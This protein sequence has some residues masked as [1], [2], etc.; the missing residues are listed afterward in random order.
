MKHNLLTAANGLQTPIERSQRKST[1]SSIHSTLLTSLLALF[2]LMAGN[3]AMW[4]RPTIYGEGLPG[5]NASG[6]S[7]WDSNTKEMSA[8][9]E[10]NTYYAEFLNVAATDNN[11]YRFKIAVNDAGNWWDGAMDSNNTSESMGNVDIVAGNETQISFKMPFAGDVYVFYKSTNSNESKVWIVAVPTLSAIGNTTAQSKT[12]KYDLLIKGGG[13]NTTINFIKNNVDALTYKYV[14]SYVAPACTSSELSSSKPP[15]VRYE[16]YTGSGSDKYSGKNS[17]HSAELTTSVRRVI[18]LWDGNKNDAPVK[19]LIPSYPNRSS[20]SGWK[21]WANDGTDISGDLSNGS[22]TV[23]IQGGKTVKYFI[24]N[25]TSVTGPN[26]DNFT[27]NTRH[28]VNSF[29]GCYVDKTASSNVTFGSDYQIYNSNEGGVFKIGNIAK[30]IVAENDMRGSVTIDGS[31][32]KDVTFTFDGGVITINAVDHGADPEPPTPSGVT[33]DG[34]EYIYYAKQNSTSIGDWN[35][36]NDNCAMFMEFSDGSTEQRSPRVAFFWD[37]EGTGGNVLAAQVPEG[38]WTKCRLLRTRN[39]E[40]GTVWNTSDWYNLDESKNYL[41][42]GATWSTHDPRTFH[43]YISGSTTLANTGS[44]FN[45]WNGNGTAHSGSMTKL[46]NAGT[47]KFKLNPTGTV[48]WRSEFNM[49]D[50]DQT[51]SNV[52]L[53]DGNNKEIWFDLA[54]QSEVTIAC[55]GHK[56]TVNATPYV[57]ALTTENLYVFGAGGTNWVT[58][59]TK[60]VEDY[61]MTITTGIASKTF[62]NVS[63]SGLN[64]KV[65]NQTN[66]AEYDWSK[67][68]ESSC[69]GLSSLSNCSANNICFNLAQASDVTV[70]TDGTHVWLTAV[71][72]PVVYDG[73][74]IFYFHKTGGSLGWSSVYGG[75]AAVFLEFSNT[76][77]SSTARSTKV[78]YFWDTDNTNGDI[79]ATRVPAGTWNKVRVKRYGWNTG[80]QTLGGDYGNNSNWVTLE[81]GKNYLNGSNTMDVYSNPRT[82]HFY[83]SG[84]TALANTGSEF[85]AWNGNGTAHSGSITKTLN[86]GTYKFKLNPTGTQDWRSEF[87]MD[88]LDATNSSN[89]INLRSENNNEIWFDLA[90]RSQVTIACDGS[91]VTVVATPVQQYTVT[92]NTDGG[93][94]I[95]PV[96]VSDGSP[97]AQPADPTKDGYNFVKWQLSGAD[98][99]FSSPVTS[100][101]TLTAVW[102]YKA[103]ESVSLNENTHM[104]WVGNSD[105]V[106]TLTKNPSDLITKTIVWSSDAE[107]VAAVSNGTVTAVSAGSATITC[108]V[109]D[110]ND[111]VRSATCEVTVAACQMIVDNLYSMT[112][113]GYNDRSGDNAD[114]DGLWNESSDNT[115]PAS[116]TIMRL[117]FQKKDAGHTLYAYDDN[118]TVKVKEDA[119]GTDVQW[120]LIPVGEN[121]TPSWN[122]G[123]ACQLYYIKNVSSG[124]YMHRGSAGVSTGNE[125]W[126]YSVTNTNATNAAT[127]DY[128]WFIINEND[129]E[130]CIFVKSGVGPNKAR[131]YKL[132]TSNQYNDCTDAYAAKPMLPVGRTGDINAY[133][134]SY[135]NTNDFNYDT[136]ANPNY[137][138]SQMNGSYYRMKENATVRANLANGLAYGSVITVRLYA[139]E[140]TSVKLQTAAG[141]DVETINLSADAAREYTYTVAYGSELVGA[142]AFIIKAADNHAGIASIEVSRMHAVSPADPELAWDAD[143]SGGV[144]QSA[145]AGTFQHVASSALSDG[146][147]HYVSSN[148]AVAT[149]AADGT[150]TPIMAGNTT[151]TATIEQRECYAEA[152]ITY[153]VTLTEASLAELIAADAGAGITLTH[154]YAENIVIDKAVTIDGA[155]HAIGNLTVEMAGDLTLSGALTVNDF[156]ICAKAGNTSNPA[157]S[158][159]VRNANNLTVNGNAYF[160]YTV[161]PSGTVHYGWYDFTVPFPV[162]AASGI[163][164]IDG[165]GLKENFA[166]GVDYAIMEYLGE[167]QG[168]GQYPY[169]KF[170]GVMQPNKLYSIT[171]DSRDNYNTLRMQKTTEGA[172]VAGDNVTLEAYSGDAQHQNWNGVGN[173]TLHHADAGNPTVDFVQVYQSGDKTFLPV[174]TSDYSFVV[175]TAFMVQEEGTMTLSQ[176]THSK[177]LAPARQA[178]APATAIQIASEGQPFSD[179]LFISASET[180]GQ[181][182][183][184]G[185]DVAKAGNIGN[186][187]V[188]QIWTNAYDTKLCVH[189]AQLINGEAQYNLSLYAPAAGTYTLTSLN[190]PADYT[191]YL[192]QNGTTISELSETYRLDLSNGITTEYGLLL[193]ESHKIPTGLE[194]VQNDNVQ[195]TKVLLNGV[196]YIL[197]NGKVYN[198]Q[199]G[200]ME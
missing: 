15:R 90:N 155:G 48:D 130:R 125:D 165:S 80:N 117:A 157:A 78:A 62:Y 113:T 138:A 72:S 42:S 51:N 190:I 147:V 185:I 170:S 28:S 135:K 146:A 149:V 64:F 171:L 7:N 91:K 106:L 176:A 32:T 50:V 137:K 23:Q 193:I 175:G 37:S 6:A 148:P 159:Q 47:Y 192:T 81:S 120:I 17:P 160:L 61:K 158:G 131:S 183:T 167:K 77:E 19:Y 30:P 97:V 10:A 16:A 164:G 156:T 45:A 182:Y 98:Y 75:D 188:P 180:G 79:L 25:S 31:G 29:G 184:P 142:T 122:G 119:S 38:T 186:V 96:Q 5:L 46:L 70:Y 63:G 34:S 112:V 194:N 174:S 173:G 144:E 150:V 123:N 33:Y 161:D 154:D 43:F 141:D 153:D 133:A 94:T 49:D 128:K 102:A 116:M 93:S 105:F 1:T 197:H 27:D 115:E 85:N 39:E 104:T 54:T 124:K 107:G 59:W 195:C 172:L 21:L 109:T 163:K 179:Q 121:Y 139:D 100:N 187:N 20:E 200:L 88:D 143:L 92:F 84:S 71:P 53:Y 36:W 129:N 145:L 40:R 95:D 127:D 103:I 66:S 110:M 151:I 166:N 189:E 108:T 11:T 44:D 26:T 67:I 68:D 56:V 8:Y 140:A 136:Y 58:D 52:T 89:D 13:W 152:F 134:K 178:S 111:N 86:A 162:N 83:I 101:I 73:S 169:K 199:G 18:Y 198:A 14:T 114:L 4:A 82:F 99:N 87:N 60:N 74:E 65:W 12:M 9:G 177:L 22:V 57:P 2:L 118:G 55:D 76:D 3:S 191:L 168:L 24:T 196:L 35:Y 126:W 181:A 132:H 41:A 69:S